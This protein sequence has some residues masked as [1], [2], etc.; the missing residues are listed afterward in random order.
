M[1]VLII[2]ILNEKFQSILLLPKKKV[3]WFLVVIKKKEKRKERDIQA[4]MIFLS[5]FYNMITDI[6]L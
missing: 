1:L 4:Y 2:S 3:N 6:F 5:C